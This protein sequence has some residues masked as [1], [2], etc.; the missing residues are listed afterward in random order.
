MPS[1]CDPGPRFIAPF[2][3]D[4]KNLDHWV[5]GGRY[6]WDNG[7][8]GWNT[9][10]AAGAATGRS[11]ATRGAGRS[12]TAIA[13]SGATTYVGVVRPVQRPDLQV[14]ASTRTPDGTWHSIAATNLP[15]RFVNALTV[16]PANTAHVYAVYNGFSRR[17]TNDGGFRAT[18]SSRTTPAR[19]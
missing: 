19:R 16:D 17:W 7:G 14:A 6:V 13:V 9:T 11:S 15:N 1:P 8:K 18:S 10:C 12:I 5:A 3:A 4:I 2:R